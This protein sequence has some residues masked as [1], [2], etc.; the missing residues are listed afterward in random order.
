MQYGMN[1]WLFYCSDS[2]ENANGQ[3]YF[4]VDPEL[5]VG[6]SN[7]VLPLDAIQLHTVLP[8]LLGPFPEWRDRLRVSHI[9]EYNMIHFTPLQQLNLESNSSYSISDQLKINP[10]FST[11]GKI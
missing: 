6:S 5:K 2:L 1:L 10:A 11:P 9:S 4:L 7:T 3:G 8:K